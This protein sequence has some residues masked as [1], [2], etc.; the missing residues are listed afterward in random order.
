MHISWHCVQ[1]SILFY[2][3]RNRDFCLMTKY[4]I[5]ILY[6]YDLSIH[7]IVVCLFFYGV[8]QHECL[9]VYLFNYVVI[10]NLIFG[11]SKQFLRLY[12]QILKI[13]F[14]CLRRYKLFFFKREAPFH[15]KLFSG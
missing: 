13:V 4:E 11:I 9:S 10:Q 1:L 2:R 8:I 12:F 6:L 7:Y 15:F 14:N 3:Q 5:Q